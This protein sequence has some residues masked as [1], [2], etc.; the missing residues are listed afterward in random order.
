MSYDPETFGPADFGPKLRALEAV[1]DRMVTI[2]NEAVGIQPVTPFDELLTL[3]ERH[4]FERRVEFERVNGLYEIAKA[5]VNTQSDQI[6]ELQGE[7]AEEREQRRNGVLIAA[8]KGLRE[9]IRQGMERAANMHAY[10]KPAC[11]HER[12]AGAP[13]A[14]AIGAVIEY[15][16][17]IRAEAVKVAGRG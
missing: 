6:Q 7:L 4:L 10:V 16:D 13:G 3:L 5:L 1:L 12:E 8:G 9:G 17:L 2:V 11:E 14:G 15:R